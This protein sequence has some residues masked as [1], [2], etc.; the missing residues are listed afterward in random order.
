MI[1]IIDVTDDNFSELITEGIILVDFSAEWCGSCKVLIPI[2]E[3]LA[4]NNEELK[5][6]K[7][8]VEKCSETATR[9]GIRSVP[10]LMFF[11]N[12]VEWNKLVG[13]QSIADLQ[14]QVDILRGSNG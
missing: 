11:K 1:N 12:G 14:Q 5:V 4:S 7:V 9:F 6:I 13:K 3:E 8:D 10:T 2:L